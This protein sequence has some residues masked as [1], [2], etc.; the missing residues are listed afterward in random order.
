MIP[1]TMIN[2]GPVK[3]ITISGGRGTIQ[4]LSS[5]GIVQGSVV[6]VVYNPGRGPIIIQTGNS[7]FAIGYGMARKVYV[8]PVGK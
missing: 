1:L 7:K 3:I 4:R 6:N 5:L 8:V 2:N